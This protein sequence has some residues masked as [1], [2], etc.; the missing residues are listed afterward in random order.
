MHLQILWS[1]GEEQFY[2]FSTHFSQNF[3]HNPCS[4]LFRMNVIVVTMCLL[5]SQSREIKK[6]AGCFF[7][8]MN[9][10]GKR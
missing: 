4:G 6:N 5:I 2:Q 7:L 8:L 10:W 3:S 1:H 9:H